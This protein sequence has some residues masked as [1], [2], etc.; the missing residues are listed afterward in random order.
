MIRRH[1]PDAPA[2]PTILPAG[3][4]ARTLT[5]VCPCVLRF[6]PM[7]LN[8]VQMAA[9]HAEDEHV[10]IAVIDEAVSFYS[11]FVREYK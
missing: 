6:A 3:T 7:R 9:I 5:D 4:D 8:K 10:D 11:D 1:F 2:A